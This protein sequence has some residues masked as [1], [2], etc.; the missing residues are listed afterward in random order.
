MRKRTHA[1]PEP[2]TGRPDAEN[3]ESL[4]QARL[5]SIG[6]RHRRERE[7]HLYA[8]RLRQVARAFPD[9]HMRLLAMADEAE[10]HGRVCLPRPS[11]DLSLLFYSGGSVEEYLKEDRRKTGKADTCTVT[12]VEAYER[13]ERGSQAE[14]FWL[15]VRREMAPSFAKTAIPFAEL[16]TES[17]RMLCV[18]RLGGESMVR[19]ALENF[20]RE[21]ELSRAWLSVELARAEW[22]EL[23]GSTRAGGQRMAYHERSDLDDLL[24]GVRS[25]AVR[26][27]QLGAPKDVLACLDAWHYR[28]LGAVDGTPDTPPKYKREVLREIEAVLGRA[29]APLGK[30]KTATGDRR[31]YFR[32]RVELMLLWRLSPEDVAILE[33]AW[34]LPVNVSADGSC[35][36]G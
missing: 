15:G 33:T 35:Q 18:E 32:R 17:A 5:D 9:P 20:Y 19:G 13:E 10:Q 26:A 16:R 28:V 36:A 21:F 29:E 24:V 4:F 3:E 11:R 7:D 25:L 14:R 31:R 30:R 27:R 34:L 2:A 6:D 23:D 1:A 22:R 8:T 12:R